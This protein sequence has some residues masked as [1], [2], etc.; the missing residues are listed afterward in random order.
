MAKPAHAFLLQQAVA[1]VKKHGSKAAAARA[2]GIPTNTLKDRLTAAALSPAAKHVVKDEELVDYIRTKPRTLAQI[3]ERF[4]VAEIE[5]DERVGALAK[6]GYNVFAH[7]QFISIEK[8]PIP[9]ASG[10]VA[11]AD[12][13]RLVANENGEIVFGVCSDNHLGSKYA[14]EDVLHDLYDWFE[15]EGV[16]RVYNAGNWIDGEARFNKF[17]L[18]VHGMQAQIDYFCEN[19]PQRAGIDTYYV[20]GDDHEGW[21]CK[22]SGVDIGAMTELNAR[23][24]FGRTDLHYLAYMEAYIAM[25][26][27]KTGASSQLMVVHPGGGSSYAISYAPQ[28][29]AEALQ[30]GE[31]PAV[32]VFGH[33]HKM[34]VFNYRNVWLIQAGTTEDQTPFMRKQKLEAHVGGLIVRLKL[35]DRGA[36][37]ECTTTQ[38]RYFDRGYHNGSFSPSGP[39][40]RPPLKKR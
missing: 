24:K 18:K 22:D 3:A 11:D 28:K 26:H 9:N 10:R 30:G 34:D 5:I 33:W 16:K 29:F 6:A 39:V 2:L 12:L 31:K 36:V 4:K 21:Y 35:D 37:I 19:Y 13:F 1:A 14:R 23:E 20:A 32:I 40:T 7:G 15:A 27:P 25:V 8:R 38:R 17:D